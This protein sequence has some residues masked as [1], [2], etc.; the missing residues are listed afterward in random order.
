MSSRNVAR[1]GS[2]RRTRKSFGLSTLEAAR[3]FEFKRQGDL[4]GWHQQ[5]DGRSFL[6]LHVQA[7]RISDQ[8]IPAE[9]GLREIV[10]F[11][12]EIRLTPSQNLILANV[13]PAAMEFDSP[14]GTGVR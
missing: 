4:F 2:E 3:S 13:D 9:V 6:G 8:R 12:A 7:G 11:Q 14:I 10:E 5:R 1:T